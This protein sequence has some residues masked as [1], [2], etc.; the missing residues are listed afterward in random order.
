MSVF[1]LTGVFLA[2]TAGY[3]LPKVGTK[4]LGLVALGS[5]A[6]GGCLGVIS[7]GPEL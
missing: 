4:A 6:V 3:L 1:A 5:L 7:K 2:L